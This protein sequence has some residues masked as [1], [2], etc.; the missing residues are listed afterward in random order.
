MS[1]RFFLA[2]GLT[3][4]LVANDAAAQVIPKGI[5]GFQMRDSR[6]TALANLDH[7]SLEGK[8][9]RKCGPDE[10][11]GAGYDVCIQ[12]VAGVSLANVPIDYIQLAFKNE[13]LL[14][15]F[16]WAT[17][18]ADSRAPSKLEVIRSAFTSLMQTPPATNKDQVNYWMGAS[19]AVGVARLNLQ[20]TLYVKAFYEDQQ[21]V[22]DYLRATKER[23]Q[24]LDLQ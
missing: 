4:S 7:L 23:A 2:C 20:G 21:Q 18:N 19:T 16:F 22:L 14:A 9:Q 12:P 8:E 11:F 17:D 1:R 13:Q 10:G 5:K 3:L 15:V 6:V 24:Q